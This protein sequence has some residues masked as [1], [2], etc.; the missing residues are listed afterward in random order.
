[1]VFLLWIVLL[2]LLFIFQIAT[3]LICEYKRPAKSVAWLSIL[4]IFPIIGFV[5]YYFF[6]R[7][8]VRRK[9]VHEV[10]TEWAR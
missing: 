6:A 8:Y 10:S 7:E 4:Y 9:K 2:L 5:M 1:M 3:I